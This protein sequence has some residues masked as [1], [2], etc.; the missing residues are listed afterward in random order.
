MGTKL[1]PP[2]GHS[3]KDGPVPS[4]APQPL[5]THKLPSW[6]RGVQELPLSPLVTSGKG[7]PWDLLPPWSQASP[8][9]EAKDSALLS[10]RDAGLLE[11]PERPQ[12]S[13][14]SSSVWSDDRWDPVSFTLSVAV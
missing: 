12:G 6:P 4:P 14:A 5:C 2:S 3:H 9:G 11:P 13:P 7:R 8:R 1:G 10:S